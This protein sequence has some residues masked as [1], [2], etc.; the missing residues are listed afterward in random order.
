MET[1][2]SKSARHGAGPTAAGVVEDVDMVRAIRSRRE[3]AREA[4]LGDFTAETNPEYELKGRVLLCGLSTYKSS[5]SE[6]RLMT[7]RREAELCRS[8]AYPTSCDAFM[9]LKVSAE[10]EVSER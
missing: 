4:I 2:D 8:L 1:W 6:G 9:N 5:D 10:R 3:M 7:L